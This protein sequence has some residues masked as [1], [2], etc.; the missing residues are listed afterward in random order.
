MAEMVRNSEDLLTVRLRVDMSSRGLQL[1]ADPFRGDDPI[2]PPLRMPL[3]MLG[4]QDRQADR[5]S[6]RMYFPD[7][8]DRPPELSS[9]FRE[10]AAQADGPEAIWLQIDY[11]SDILAAYP[12]EAHFSENTGRALL[13][14]PNF[15]RNTYRRADDSQPIAICAGTPH[16]KGA[17]NWERPLRALLQGL[18]TRQPVVLYLGGGTGRDIA[19]R[20][21]NFMSGFPHLDL[22]IASLP[23]TDNAPRRETYTS[24]RKTVS[25]PW[26]RWI[27]ERQQGPVH[28]VHFLCTGF[29]QNQHGAL[30]LPESPAFD[31]DR[32]WARFVGV[33]EFAAFADRLNC[34]ITGFT[35]LG[36]SLWREG[37][38]LFAN[39]LSWKRP[40][41]ILTEFNDGQAPQVYN[42]L[43]N[44]REFSPN[45]APDL[46]LSVHP[47]RS[48]KS[49][50][51]FRS[52]AA[53]KTS[54]R[55]IF[56]RSLPICR[57]MPA[58]A[59]RTNCHPNFCGSWTS[60]P[61]PSPNRSCALLAIA[62][63][64]GQCIS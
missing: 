5:Y 23:D 58:P 54:G 38:R 53:C 43:L 60:F 22:R 41:P 28:A 26:L 25:N 24:S 2:G 10:T 61:A 47:R 62:A 15:A 30:A 40:G 35:A 44:G 31:N 63:R 1:V 37:L 17:P 14:I 7:G 36:S 9:F 64:S 4:Y 42:A 13:R 39:E 20:S 29:A 56:R 19:S 33:S 50:A 3:E 6:G 21:E 46:T 49:P 59:P 16:A 18:E 57:P 45:P 27:L 8:G 52:R 51:K 48:A 32:N 55:W 34:Q 11:G 12:W